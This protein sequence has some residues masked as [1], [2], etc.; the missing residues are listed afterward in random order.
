M[1]MDHHQAQAS[2]ASERY[3]LG[4]MSEP[5][6]FAFEEHY[7][8]CEECADDVRAGTA[9]ARG[10]KAIGREEAARRPVVADR[11][12]R[13]SSRWWN[14]LSPA[15]LIPAAAAAMLA[16]VVGYQSL[17]TIPELSESRALDTVVLRAAARGDE[18]TID[19]HDGQP[20]TVLSFDVNAAEPGAPL[21][22]EIEPEGGAPRIQGAAKVPPPGKPMQV[23][24][25]HRKLDRTGAWT[26]ILKT[27]QGAE[28]ARYPFQLH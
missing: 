15:A 3:L 11:P 13:A 20:F 8:Q 18:Q 17:V 27:P 24:V 16:C 14:W 26:L 19:T 21:R 5:E 4:E 10:I 22:Y 2:Q 9:L 7:F 25:P 12:E 23:T 6:R 28:I 1:S